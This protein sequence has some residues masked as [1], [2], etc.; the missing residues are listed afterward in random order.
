MK[1]A[2]DRQNEKRRFQQFSC[3][4]ELCLLMETYS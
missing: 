3:D 2:V 1:R 4:M